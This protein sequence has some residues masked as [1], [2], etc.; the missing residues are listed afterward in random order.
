MNKPNTQILGNNFRAVQKVAGIF[1][2]YSDRHNGLA[3]SKEAISSVDFLKPLLNIDLTP[4]EHEDDSN[5]YY[6]ES[7]INQSIVNSLLPSEVYQRVVGAN[8]LEQAATGV[9]KAKHIVKNHFPILFE[10]MHG[11]QISANESIGIAEAEFYQANQNNY[12]IS[13]LQSDVEFGTSGEENKVIVKFKARK[14]SEA[15][16]YGPSFPKM[17]A[18]K[19]PMSEYETMVKPHIET[20]EY[21]TNK[22]QQIFLP[23]HVFAQIEQYKQAS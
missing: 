23:S 10:K 18:V 4:F 16:I 22:Q 17:V 3:I 14:L 19:L 13:S 15:E 20:C 2:V 12:L 1:L 8:S 9:E 21:P 5:F 7:H 6:F 11:I